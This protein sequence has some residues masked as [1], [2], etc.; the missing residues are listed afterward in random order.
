[1]G[2]GAMKKN[3]IYLRIE[4]LLEE[5]KSERIR[6]KARTA[7]SSNSWTRQRKMPL[8]EIIM[9][10][11]IK[12]GL[13]ATMEVRKYFQEAGIVEQTVSKQ[14]YLRQRQKLNPE[15]FK[16]LNGNY[17]K[18]FYEGEEARVWRGYLVMAVDGSRAEIP[19]S[20]E[21]RWIYGESI[22]KYGKQAARAN[23]SALHDV[24]ND[25]ILDVVIDDYRGSE[26]KAAKKH[27]EE[28]KETV[29]ER[30]VLLMFDRNYASLEFM[31]FLEKSGVT[32]LI[33]LHSGDY[34]A[35]ISGMKSFDEEV[36]IAYNK[37]RLRQLKKTNPRRAKELEQEKTARIRAVKIVL[38]NGEQAVF[39]TNLREGTCDDIQ[40][41][42]K[43]RWS[44][45]KKYHTLKNKLKFESVTGKASVYVLQDFWAQML[46][47]NI[48]Q[49]LKK[50]A[51][52][53]AARKSRRKKLKY[54]IRINENIAIGLFK[55]QFIRLMV[56]GDGRLKEEIFRR[57]IADMEK[58]IVPVRKLKSS[59][60]KFRYFN[61]YK[62]NQKPSF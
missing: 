6:K 24:F 30:P 52:N 51:E 9:C 15:V 20:K 2:K 27:L 12:K 62:C 58:H 25:F 4:R 34:S 13:T 43:Q 47:F 40:R 61:K 45:E 22:N 44:I 21:N 18:G 41:L 5:I 3:A 16:V 26:I 14:D 59:P 32:Y 17:L 8:R 60:R 7:K 29:R 48:V 39:M 23:I 57:L 53:R 49:D 37:S 31:D 10:A 38:A 54:E 56:E 11:L 19:N 35:E 36:E 46:V 55:E 28:L 50:A 33:R 42:Y 1:M